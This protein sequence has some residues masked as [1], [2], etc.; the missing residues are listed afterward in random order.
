MILYFRYGE[1]LNFVSE[2]SHYDNDKTTE[3]TTN[4]SSA[5]HL[6]VGIPG[7]ERQSRRAD[8]LIY[9]NILYRL[10]PQSVSSAAAQKM[11]SAEGNSGE[12]SL[13][14][15][16]TTITTKRQ[17]RRLIRRLLCICSSGYRDSNPGPPTP[18]AGALTGLRYIPNKL[19]LKNP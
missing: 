19:T 10:N 13:A 6:L 11:Q 2:C 7:F 14:S 18:E 4:K 9:N 15:A 12:K 5:L 8:T 16:R 17:S 3:Q 1:F